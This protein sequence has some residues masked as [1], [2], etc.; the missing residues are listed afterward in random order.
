M[1]RRVGFAL[2]LILMVSSACSQTPS[3]LKQLELGKREVRAAKLNAALV[4]DLERNFPDAK[5][6]VWTPASLA[7]DSD[8]LIQSPEDLWGLSE[9][10]IPTNLDCSTSDS[11][12]DRD[13][14]RLSCETTAD[15]SSF[16]QCESMP[17][18]TKF[19]SC[20][21]SGPPGKRSRT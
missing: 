12:C 17:A 19:P 14:L 13:F 20:V 11:R 5:G 6:S 7:L 15:C 21:W 16:T 1:R 3:E 9:E 10:N 18:T 2:V 4:A 8:W